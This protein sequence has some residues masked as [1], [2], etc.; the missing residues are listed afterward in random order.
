MGYPQ[1]AAALPTA[2]W[3]SHVLLVC[4]QMAGTAH[5]WALAARGAGHP[6][7]ALP[8]QPLGTTQK[9]GSG[10]GRPPLHAAGRPR[11]RPAQFPAPPSLSLS[12][13]LSSSQ[14]FLWQSSVP[15]R[16]AAPVSEELRIARGLPESL[17][18]AEAVLGG[19]QSGG[20][21]AS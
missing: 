12:Q 17:L 7:R 10:W 1:G 19:L 14:L 4:P 21:R 8:H 16:I 13:A 2:A 20:S 15:F 6:W 5:S 18:R 11:P 9:P 3:G